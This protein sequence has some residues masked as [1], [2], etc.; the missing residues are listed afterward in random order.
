QQ[1]I[2]QAIRQTKPTHHDKVNE[3]RI[4]RDSPNKGCFDRT[5]TDIHCNDGD[6]LMHSITAVG[7]CAGSSVGDL[8]G[9]PLLWARPSHSRHTTH[10]FISQTSGW[11]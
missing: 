6:L 7:C 4:S 1:H 10:S 8:T 2:F 9:I 11:D 3:S 5:G